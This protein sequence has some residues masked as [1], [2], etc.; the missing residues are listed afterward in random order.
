M[1]VTK[2]KTTEQYP[3]FD[4]LI[5]YNYSVRVLKGRRRVF[6]FES[7]TYTK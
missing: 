6:K 2:S 1:K 5:Y 3:N 7:K 4:L